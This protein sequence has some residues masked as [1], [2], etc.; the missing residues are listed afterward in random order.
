[1]MQLSTIE[2]NKKGD[3]LSV[4]ISENSSIA[5]YLPKAGSS[6]L[7]ISNPETNVTEEF[8]LTQIFQSY[9]SIE[10]NLPINKQ[11]VTFTAIR[12]AE[13]RAILSLKPIVQPNNEAF[14]LESN[15][16]EAK[17]ITK[18]TIYN[19]EATLKRFT[20]NLPLVVFEIFLY[21]DGKFE[22]GFVNKEME[23][24]FPA[25]NREAI[26]TDNSLLFVRVHPDDKQKLIDSIKTD[27][28]V[29]END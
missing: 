17:A 4:N 29:L 10:F 7:S 21:P 14:I 3:V 5:A 12:I 2:I 25:F 13:D 24:F 26:N 1:M 8:P 19:A 23:K 9:L 15:L 11:S 22:F 28:D 16:E 18:H 27:L 6:I 20:D